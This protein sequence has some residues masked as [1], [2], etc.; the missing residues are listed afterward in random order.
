MRCKD[1]SRALGWLAELAENDHVN[2]LSNWA[3]TVAHLSDGD[4]QSAVIASESAESWFLKEHDRVSAARV[5]IPRVM[6]LAQLGRV[7]EAEQCARKALSVFVEVRDLFSAGKV[8]LNLG[9]LLLQQDR[10]EEAVRLYRSASV[11]FARVGNSEY[12]ILADI[13]HADALTEQLRFDEALLLYERANARAIARNAMV[14]IAYVR[15]SLGLLE[16]YRGNVAKSLRWLQLACND[17][18]KSD[19]ERQLAE[20]ELDMAAAY[21]EAGLLPEADRLYATVI[22][23]MASVGSRVEQTWATLHRGRVRLRLGQFDSAAALAVDA[24]TRFSRFDTELGVAHAN[25]LIA[26][27][28]MA[29]NDAAL[30]DS[31]LNEV[32]RICESE[33]SLALSLAAELVLGELYASRSQDEDARSTFERTRARAET[34][35]QRTIAFRASVNLARLAERR[36]DIERAMASYERAAA[37]IETQHRLLQSDDLKQSYRASGQLVFDRLVHMHAVGGS[38]AD[39]FSAMERARAYADLNHAPSSHVAS[40]DGALSSQA[41]TLNA[42][43]KWAIRELNLAIENNDDVDANQETVRQLEQALIETTRRER[44]ARLAL[45]SDDAGS[46]ASVSIEAIQQVLGSGDA[47]I[48]Y[49]RVERDCFACVITST[50]ASIH[51]IDDTDIATSVRN[52][53]FQINA[54]SGGATS[55]AQHRKLLERRVDQRLTQL[56][57]LLLSPMAEVLASKHRLFIVPHGVLHYV[58]FAALG[59]NGRPLI[60]RTMC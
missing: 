28:A 3:Q 9:S 47:V 40:S 50:S 37:E 13:G 53:R 25:L 22:G 38:V 27:I 19:D 8:E 36:A 31:R 21:A 52:T 48:E 11:R 17:Y 33:N 57:T 58:P 1:A 7:E 6:A 42:Q 59:W 34:C 14:S 15:Q 12:S 29:S 18:A 49:Y 5:S 20:C 46:T 30:A 41:S 2:A 44:I 10:Y 39:T 16:C 24:Y 4:M 23:R 56:G 35:G 55:L 60:P 45:A 51:R 54:M 26:E 32:V 43:L